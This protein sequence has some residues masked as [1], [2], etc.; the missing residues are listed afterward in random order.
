[1]FEG[2]YFITIVKIGIYNL[3]LK[4]SFINNVKSILKFQD[5]RHEPT[6]DKMC[7]KILDERIRER[8]HDYRLNPSFQVKTVNIFFIICIIW[9]F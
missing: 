3:T 6:F 8:S 9:R 1:M 4:I 5:H 7:L 2:Q